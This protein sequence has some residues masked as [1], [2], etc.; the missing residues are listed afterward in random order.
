MENILL[1]FFRE[2]NEYSPNDI[3]NH[4]GISKEEYH[5]IETGNAL[6]KDL[7]TQQ[8]AK[9]FKIKSDYLKKSAYQLDLLLARN[10]MI[11]IQR[12]EIQE[13]NQQI[14]DLQKAFIIKS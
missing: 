6:L 4:L 2:L 12:R 11:K 14:Q 8:L 1:R 7:Q 13:L 10:E 3:A 5:D 9:L